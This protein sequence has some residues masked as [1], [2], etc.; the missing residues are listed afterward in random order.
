MSF[1]K[2]ACVLLAL[3]ILGAIARGDAVAVA[4]LGISLGLEATVVL[5]ELREKGH[6]HRHR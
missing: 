4:L 2:V 6:D 1:A 5:H 3:A